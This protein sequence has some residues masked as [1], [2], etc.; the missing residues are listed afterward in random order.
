[1][2]VQVTNTGSDLG[3]NQFDLA[4]PGGGEGIFDGC[5]SQF[6][7]GSYDW[8]AQ[9]GGVSARSDCENLPTILQP[10]CYWR[11]DWFQNANNPSM[12]F[13][14]VSC[15]SALTANTQCIRV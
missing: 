1:M 9:Y 5:Q 13:E 10:G 2:I 14:E 4:M 15:P 8:G 6:T 3:N 12:N 7:S 11:F